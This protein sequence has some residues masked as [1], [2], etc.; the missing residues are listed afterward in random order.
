MTA[1]VYE[2]LTEALRARGGGLPALKCREF[3]ALLEEIFTPDE[4]EIAAKM[5][6]SP[7]PAATFAWEIAGEPQDVEKLLEAMADKGLVMTLERGGVRHYSLMSL[8]P[9]I[10]ETQVMKGEVNDYTKKYAHLFQEYSRV[11][12][13]LKEEIAPALSTFPSARVIT[14]E[15]EISAGVEIYPYDKVSEYIANS[16]YIGLTT[17]AC[18]NLGELVGHPCD[19]PKDVCMFFGPLA[20]YIAE[21]GFGRSISR[22]E[23]LSVLDRAEKAGLVHCTSNTAEH[24]EFICNCC[25]CHCGILRSIKKADRP[26]MGAT[27]GFI[28]VVDEEKCMGCGDCIDRCPMEALSIEGDIV[29]RDSSRCIGCGLCISVCPT[30][31]LRMEPREERPIPARDSNE[32][33]IAMNS[34]MPRDEALPAG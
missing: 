33:N 13:G 20:K 34:S 1:P 31:A 14:V 16:D 24:I 30:S 11:M 22:E 18:R 28:T 25:V 19:K 17:C 32:L 23:A 29:V 15:Q 21:R 26:S 3:Y 10:I 9:G 4:A 5:P 7:I 6:V 2:Q 8:F 27:S 12:F